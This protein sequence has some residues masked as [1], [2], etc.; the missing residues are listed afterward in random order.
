[1]VTSQ[2]LFWDFLQRSTMIF[3]CMISTTSLLITFHTC[4]AAAWFCQI[5]NQIL[6]VLCSKPSSSSH[7]TPNKNQMIYSFLSDLISYHSFQ[8][9]RFR[10][11]WHPIPP[12]NISGVLLLF[13]LQDISL[14]C[15]L[16]LGFSS[17]CNPHGWLYTFLFKCQN[18]REDFPNHPF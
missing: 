8:A 3:H 10:P 14:C 12:K 1:M 4:P 2:S 5:L 7:L 15:F 18:L 16:F 9:H 17:P 13:S 11:C 6:S